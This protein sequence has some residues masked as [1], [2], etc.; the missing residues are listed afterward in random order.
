MGR[1]EDRL[2]SLCPV[3]ASVATEGVNKLLGGARIGM[4][5]ER[6]SAEY[7]VE[8]AEDYRVS[9]AKPTHLAVSRGAFLP[10]EQVDRSQRRS[11]MTWI[12]NDGKSAQK[13]QTKGGKTHD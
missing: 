1:F 11:S 3:G 13:S 9:V 2:C 8:P 7:V 5:R 4:R 10:G 12:G 6:L